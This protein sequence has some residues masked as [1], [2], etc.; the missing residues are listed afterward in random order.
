MG[1]DALEEFASPYVYVGNDPIRFYDLFGL[2]SSDTVYE[3][4]VPL[5]PVVVTAERPWWAGIFDAYD[6]SVGGVS[7]WFFGTTD[8]NRILYDA[9]YF[10]NVALPNF[11]GGLAPFGGKLKPAGKG[12]KKLFFKRLFVRKLSG[13]THHLLSKKILRALSRHP[14]LAGVY[15]RNDPRFIYQAATKEAHR[16][17]QTW[18]REVDDIV[19]KWLED[20]PKATPAKFERFLQGLYQRPD[21]AKRIPGVNLID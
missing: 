5:P 13:E 4:P 17:Y 12:L 15:S 11:L 10:G 3:D 7:W 9:D 18:H 8:Y 19:V 20:N 16:G 21:V 14:N 6:A 2:A 1:V